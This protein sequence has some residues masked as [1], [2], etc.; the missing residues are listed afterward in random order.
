MSELTTERQGLSRGGVAVV[1]VVTV[2]II[3]AF[4]SAF[5]WPGWAIRRSEPE[6]TAAPGPTISA[7]PLPDDA[8]A[9][10]SALPDSVGRFARQSVL[11]T[12]NWTSSGTLEEYTA[13]YSD[14]NADND[15]TLVM[16]QW[17]SADKADGQYGALRTGLSGTVK[18]KGSILVNGDTAGE[19]VIVASTPGEGQS[20]DDVSSTA[21]W[22]NST[23]VFRATGVYKSVSEFYAAFPL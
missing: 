11:T 13:V 4:V 20:E 17:E 5:A 22:V 10:A 19:Y 9:L 6:P 7:S 15:V 12:A 23:V 14:G 8:S 18:A 16:A 2:L 1:T 3:L 21:L